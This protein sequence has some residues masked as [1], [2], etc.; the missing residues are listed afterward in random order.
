M[1]P[2]IKAFPTLYGDSQSGKIKEW[3]IKVVK[4]MDDIFIITTSGFVDGKQ[5]PSER[6]VKEGKNIGKKNATTPQEQAI[7][8]AEKK[9][10][11]KK[12]KEEYRED[13][14][15]G[16]KVD[17]KLEIILPMLAHRYEL[18]SAKKKKKDIVFPC[19]TQ[20][21]L[22]GIRSMSTMYNN[23]GKVI[24]YSRKGK[25]FFNMEHIR[26]EL[27]TILNGKDY[28][29]DGELYSDEIPFEMINGLVKKQKDLKLDEKEKMLKIRLHLYDIFIPSSSNMGFL[30]R[31]NILQ[32]LIE[33]NNLKYISLVKNTNCNKKDEIKKLHDM[34]KDEEY[35]GIMLRNIN[36]EYLIKNRSHDLQ[37]YKEFLDA[38]YPIVGYHEGVGEDAGTIIWECE[39]INNEGNKDM[40]SVV[41]KGTNELRAQYLEECKNDFS[42]YKGKLLTVKYQELSEKNCPRFPVGIAIREDI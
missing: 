13:Y 12:E 28:Y 17:G 40:F 23:G 6:Q 15:K 18:T 1:D 41:I 27:S 33:T 35:E 39:Y 9:W 24:I 5:T 36:G 31:Y 8:E 25:E 20:P 30:E 11:D 26:N 14:E 3:S 29:L 42:Q 10:K 34:Y 38:E 32:N 16:D 19:I 21:K 37:K 4:R 7:F 2:I 22:D